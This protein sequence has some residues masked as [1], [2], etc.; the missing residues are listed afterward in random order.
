MRSTPPAD[1]RIGARRRSGV[2]PGAEDGRI[3]SGGPPGP[4]TAWSPVA[5]RGVAAPAA[6]PDFFERRPGDAGPR[7]AS[8]AAAV[9]QAEALHLARRTARQLGEEAELARRLV[10]AELGEAE[11]AQ[12]GLAARGA[13]LEHHR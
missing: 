8:G 4:V 3:P 10:A 12:F 11:G 6:T 7:V 1:D 13:G 5:T 2:V 9:E